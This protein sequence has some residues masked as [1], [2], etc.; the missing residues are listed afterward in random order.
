MCEVA[1]AN[2]LNGVRFDHPPADL[3]NILPAR[4]PVLFGDVLPGRR[5]RE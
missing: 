3:P 4:A 2:P 5:R 1:G